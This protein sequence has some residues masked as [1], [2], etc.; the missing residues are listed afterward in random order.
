MD[1]N[2]NINLKILTKLPNLE[3]LIFEDYKDTKIPESVYELKTLKTLN[4]YFDY[5]DKFEIPSKINILKLK[6]FRIMG[7]FKLKICSEIFLIKNVEIDNVE[8][9]AFPEYLTVEPTIKKLKLSKCDLYELP[10]WFDELT[11][12]KYLNLESNN[13]KEIPDIIFK[14]Y[15]LKDLRISG[16][17]I[18]FISS[19]IN[20]LK[21]EYLDIDTRII[22]NTI[23][24]IVNNPKPYDFF[25]YST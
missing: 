18:I 6:T 11:E 12:L 24:K 21:L 25:E 5:I 10:Y 7:V 22:I 1:G 2:N 23:P 13:F 15:N 17:Q 16:N 3:T 14:L 19:E 8:R 20:K 4:I 9:I